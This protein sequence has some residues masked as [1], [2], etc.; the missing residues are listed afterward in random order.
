MNNSDGDVKCGGSRSDWINGANWVCPTCKMLAPG[1]DCRRI[2]EAGSGVSENDCDKY[3]DTY[4]GGRACKLMNNSNGDRKCG[5]SRWDWMNGEMQA[6]GMD[7]TL[8]QFSRKRCHM[9]VQPQV[10][11][12]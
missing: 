6:G 9:Y 7:H 1:D 8:S 4:D 12:K 10:Y 2:S 3:Y 11:G 5:G